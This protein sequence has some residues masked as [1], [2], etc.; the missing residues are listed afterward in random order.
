MGIRRGIAAI[1]TAVAIM[2]SGLAVGTASAEEVDELPVFTNQGPIIDRE[3]VDTWNP[4]K[5]FIF[6]SVF[7]AA[8]HLDDPLGEWY[9]YYAPHDAPGGINLMYA[10]SLD[11]PWT[12]Y[13]GNPIVER[14]WDEHYSVSH[15]SSPD[16]VWNDE[17]GEVFLYFHGENTTDRY[18]TSSD[19][20][21]FEY[22]GEV[23]STTQFGRDSTE[24]SYN[25][26]FANP[27]PE[28][29][30]EYAM[31]FMVN[32]SSN[33]RRIALAY[34]HDGVTWEAQPGWVVEPG[35]AEGTNVA[36]ADLWEWNGKHYVVYG[37]SVGTIFAREL[38]ESLRAVG[39]PQP[40]YIPVPVP[41]EDG[42]ASSAQIITHDDTTHLFFEIGGRGKTTIS[43][44]LLDPEGWRDPI[45]THPSDPL[46]ELCQ[47]EGSDE[48]DGDALDDRW[49][50]L[51][52]EEGRYRVEEGA[53][54]MS[55]P[56]T[57]VDGATLPQQPVPDGAWEVTTQ[58]DYDPT[59]KYQQAGLMLYGDDEN[60]AKA[61]WGFA[62]GG[63][64][65]DFVWKKDGKDRFD[66]WAWEDSIF[67]PADMGDTAW[68]RLT[69]D[70]EWITA[71][72]ST[73]GETFV[74]LGR[75]IPVDELGATAVGPTAYRGN[76]GAPDTEASFE[77]VR[78]TPTPE[79]LEECG[80]GPGE[81]PVEDDE[82]APPAPGELSST[83]GWAHGL[84]DGE[85]ELRWNMWWGPNASRVRLYQN[86]E[87]I[88]TEDLAAAGPAA[89]RLAVPVSG[90]ADGRYEYTAEIVNSQGTTSPAP[91][92]VEVTD[93]APGIPVLSGSDADGDGAYVL[94]ANMW[95]GTNATT[96]RLLE[97][98][99]E[100]ASGELTAASPAA[101]RV[102]V[103]VEGRSAGTR[104]Y[105][106]EFSNDVGSSEGR[107]LE[108]V[109]G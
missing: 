32:D 19:G 65:F 79:E 57:S 4:N 87:L 30:W 41:P 107:P 13:E 53:L 21:D 46:Y 33:V 8:E 48:F 86:G 36:G 62:A 64:R 11:G 98:G 75:P 2:V 81:P 10:D 38:D 106:M 94:T 24:V 44:A 29:G 31:F 82:T 39:D 18:A 9:I 43:H 26:V 93:A 99:V 1:A 34:S 109:V 90:L 92:V 85:F 7:H 27:F 91:L 80:E 104:S 5:E 58:V 102:E 6:P 67:P 96:W 66:G 16:V 60:N 51:R 35:A 17:A 56:P 45:N 49:N 23:M 68:L 89:Q 42:R 84:H 37:S 76:A 83:S 73:D 40:L 3:N 69:S 47:G 78:F 74:T 77:W 15:V 95:W 101:Q 108:V 72:V 52:D 50:V 28:N 14:E 59:A 88:H 103:P 55:S 105:V 20:L 97:D 54:V 61:V 63:Q 100:I 71:A 12:Q 70:G 25:R 22:G